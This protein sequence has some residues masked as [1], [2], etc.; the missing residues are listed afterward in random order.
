MDT[1][2]T[3]VADLNMHI[4]MPQNPGMR[5]TRPSEAAP[6]AVPQEDQP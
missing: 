1:R 4:E 2:L 3:T 6:R 5:H